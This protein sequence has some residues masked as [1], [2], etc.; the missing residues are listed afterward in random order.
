[1]YTSGI[2]FAPEGTNYLKLFSYWWSEERS[3]RPL[4]PYLVG[5]LGPTPGCISS[6]P[7]V[8]S[9]VSLRE[10]LLNSLP[11]DDGLALIDVRSIN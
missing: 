5:L 9:I 3:T 7:F 8:R 2:N 6:D 10:G 1:M 11:I 4:H